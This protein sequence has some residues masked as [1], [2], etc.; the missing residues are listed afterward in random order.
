[1]VFIHHVVYIYIYIYI[2]IYMYNNI[3]NYML[4]YKLNLLSKRLKRVLLIH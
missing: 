3:I 1:M 2:Y 4:I